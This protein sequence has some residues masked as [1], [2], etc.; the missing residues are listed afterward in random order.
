MPADGE[1]PSMTS[2]LWDDEKSPHPW[3]HGELDM[4]ERKLAG[5]KKSID[6]L[7]PFLV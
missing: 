5:I 2:A 3:Q 1:V 4:L 7:V 6:S